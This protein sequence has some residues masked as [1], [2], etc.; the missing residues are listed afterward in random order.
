M[1]GGAHEGRILFAKKNQKLVELPSR[2]EGRVHLESI[3]AKRARG[4]ERER[5]GEREDRGVNWN[6]QTCEGFPHE[7]GASAEDVQY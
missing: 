2:C 3:K 1:Q 5:E 7:I 4:R 6:M